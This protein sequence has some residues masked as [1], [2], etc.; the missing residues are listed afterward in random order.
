M[1]GVRLGENKNIDTRLDCLPFILFF[2]FDRYWNPCLGRTMR[3][4]P[5]TQGLKDIAKDLLYAARGDY[6]RNDI[7]RA[8]WA[9]EVAMACDHNN[10]EAITNKGCILAAEGE[11]TTALALFERAMKLNQ[12]YTR[13]IKNF[14]LTFQQ[15]AED[16]AD[17]GE[18]DKAID[19]YEKCLAIDP[20]NDVV[21]GKLH[22]LYF[23]SQ[24]AR[25]QD[26]RPTPS[27]SPSTPSYSPPGSPMYS[28][29]SPSYSLYVHQT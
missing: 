21:K 5:W 23:L 3:S 8:F 4:G 29:E 28:P 11:L 14:F 20:V 22:S 27:Y 18:Y 12:G 16:W 6:Q 25:Q 15:I 19:I 24:N 2:L 13:A 9:N 1:T 26:R 17:E 10:M 7:D